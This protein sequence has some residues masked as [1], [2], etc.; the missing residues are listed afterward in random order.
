MRQSGAKAGH[1][2]ERLGHWSG[3]LKRG[4]GTNRRACGVQRL[5][6]LGDCG[7]AKVENRSCEYGV[8]AALQDSRRKVIDMTRAAGCDH[9]N[10]YGVRDGAG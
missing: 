7:F 10:G 3:L 4:K 5:A 1:L 9:G 8:G 6:G 2:A